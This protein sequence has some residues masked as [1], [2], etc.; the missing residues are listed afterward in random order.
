MHKYHNK[1]NKQYMGNYN[2]TTKSA[3]SLE[4]HNATQ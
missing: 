3:E 4:W 1:Q 2:V